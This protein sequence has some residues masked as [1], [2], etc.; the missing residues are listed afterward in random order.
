MAEKFTYK[1]DDY[2]DVFYDDEEA[3]YDDKALEESEI[4]EYIDD[5]T[6][7]EDENDD[8]DE[9]RDEYR[10]LEE[11]EIDKETQI[12]VDELEK[13]EAFKDN[14]EIFRRYHYDKSLTP[15][16]K[17]QMLNDLA[18]ANIKTIYYV[19]NRLRHFQNMVSL[20]EMVSAGLV[21]YAK[22][23]D[24]YDPSRN[25]KFATF[26]INCIK[27]EI[28]FCLRKEHKHFD[29]NI[30]TSY[31]RFRDKNGN[32]LLIEDTLQDNDPTPEE[33]MHQKSLRKLIF[34]NLE[35]LTPLEKYVVIYRFGLDRGI[36]LTQ[37]QIAN[38]VDMSQANISKIE[39]NC[40]DKLR[41]LMI[42]EYS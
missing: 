23:I 41:D 21:G 38:I 11:N 33:T 29:N 1:Y 22:A 35:L 7:D 20:D 39:R 17:E 28:S 26:A 13:S 3:E 4:E 18:S 40:T 16:E 10:E 2:E 37:K 36:V 14:E 15:Y 25:V 5:E 31:V 12:L 42:S 34:D 19:V 24:K 32:D 27:N 6:V 8:E 30:S 9:N